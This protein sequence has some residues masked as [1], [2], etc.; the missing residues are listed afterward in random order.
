MRLL[1]PRACFFAF[2]KNNGQLV[3]GTS[4][5]LGPGFDAAQRK[6]DGWWNRRFRV[7]KSCVV[8]FN[9]NADDA[10]WNVNTWNRDD[11]RWN[12]GNWVLSPETPIVSPPASCRGS[13]HFEAFLPP[14]DHAAEFLHHFRN[15][16]VFLGVKRARLPGDAQ[17]EFQHIG[18]LESGSYRRE[19]LNFALVTCNEEQ[20]KY[21]DE[22]R[23]DSIAERVPRFFREMVAVF[24][25]ALVYCY[26][27]LDNRQQTNG[28]GGGSKIAIRSYL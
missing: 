28:R 27:M 26:C 9:W 16:H 23:V 2:S 12:A 4:G 25:P 13:F 22:Q 15:S 24:L 11:N 5:L 17:H 21:L 18:F 8:N 3:L 14:T 19:F 1:L 7:R 10:K 20:L 6:F